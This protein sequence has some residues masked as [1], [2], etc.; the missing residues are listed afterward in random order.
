MD[1]A[2]STLE[3][4][5]TEELS[6]ALFYIGKDLISKKDFAS[7]ILWL[8]RSYKCVSNADLAALSTD[9]RELRISVI[10]SL[11]IASLGVQTTSGNQRAQ[12]LVQ[13]LQS[14][15]TEL[16]SRRF[17]LLQLELLASPLSDFFDADGYANVLF[18]MVAAFTP[19]TAEFQLLHHHIQKL[20]GKSPKLGCKVLDDFLLSLRHREDA[21]EYVEKLVITR[22]WLL[23][24]QRET[25]EEL[26][27]VQ[28]VFEKLRIPIGADTASAAQ[29]VRNVKTAQF[30]S[31]PLIIFFQL[32][33]KRIEQG[34][35]EKNYAAAVHW[36]RLA[37][38]HVFEAGG[39][40][41]RPLIER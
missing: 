14:E 28:N 8:E 11:A 12:E 19:S 13:A 23:A 26:S 18:Q 1:S 7:A 35:R 9:M 38:C 37:L 4:A 40:I 3:P 16:D 6:T 31:H 21:I 41:Y 22:V 33:W 24:H 32:I 29:T 15:N 25:Q 10:Y 27:V 20:H 34:Y 5:T 30:C 39:Q 2:E 17:Q 36:C